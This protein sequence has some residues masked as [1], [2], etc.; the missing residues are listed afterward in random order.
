MKAR[1]AVFRALADPT[2]REILRM[3]RTA[4][5]TSGEIATRFDSSWPTVSRHLG[6]LKESGLVSAHRNGQEIHYELNT[7]VFEDLVE[8]LMEWVKPNGRSS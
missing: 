8:H 2:R 6:V 3:L 4:P 7:S 1:N 5:R